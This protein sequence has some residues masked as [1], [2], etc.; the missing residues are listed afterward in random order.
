[1]AWL[2]AGQRVIWIRKNS[3]TCVTHERV[4]ATVV[5]L[6]GRRI[7]VDAQ[8]PTGVQRVSLDPRFVVKESARG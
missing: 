7:T 8:L 1:M 3:A 5:R 6:T 4:A 2:E